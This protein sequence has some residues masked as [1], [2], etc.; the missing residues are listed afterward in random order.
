MHASIMHMHA[1]LVV[2]S[3]IGVL[4]DT[5]ACSTEMKEQDAHVDS[6]IRYWA[7]LDTLACQTEIK[8]EGAQAGI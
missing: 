2:G 4:E 6:S 1:D 8:N 3:Q 5:Q 7:P